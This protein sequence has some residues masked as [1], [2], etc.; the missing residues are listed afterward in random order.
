MR[1]IAW[2]VWV[3]INFVFLGMCGFFYILCSQYWGYVERRHAF[4]DAYT[5]KKSNIGQHHIQYYTE[6]ENNF[7]HAKKLQD[8]PIVDDYLARKARASPLARDRHD[9]K[10]QKKGA[11]ASSITHTETPHS[12]LMEKISKHKSQLMIQLRRVLHDES[13]VFKARG[14]GSNPYNVEYNGPRGSYDKKTARELVC[15]LKKSGVVRTV[16]KDDEPFKSMDQGKNFPSQPLFGDDEIYE[17]CAVVSSAGSLSGS[18]LGKTIDDHEVVL[19]FNHAPTE[20]YEA[21]VGQKTTIRVVNSQV[22]SKPE[23]NFLESPLYKDIKVVAWDPSKYNHTM[24]QWYKNPDHDIFTSYFKHRLL[25]P[26]THSYLLNPAS[27]WDLWDYIQSLMPLRVRRNP[28]SSGFL[29]LALLLP[30]CAHV[31][32]FEFIPSFR[33]TKRCHYY[34]QLDDM[35]CTFGVWHPLSAEKLLLLSM[36][37]ANQTTVFHDG[38]IRIPGYQTLGC[39][40]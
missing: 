10:E 25:N 13:S 22:V 15:A 29:G 36:N 4:M 37:I 3:F 20:E 34:D 17:S 21:D 9:S 7:D 38:Y 28:P 24:E 2:S 12:K 23:F 31:D 16:M 14:E 26:E 33:M 32:M 19:R 27:L 35:S 39:S 40:D 18:H 5:N 1:A 6:T 30:H 11:K 8:G